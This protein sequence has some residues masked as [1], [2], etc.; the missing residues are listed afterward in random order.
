MEKGTNKQWIVLAMGMVCIFI[1]SGYANRALRKSIETKE[2]LNLLKASTDLM[3]ASVNALDQRVKTLEKLN[4]SSA[5]ND[6]AIPRPQHTSAQQLLTMGNQPELLY[7]GGAI[8]HIEI[9]TKN[10]D[11]SK[12]QK[13]KKKPTFSN[14]L[15]TFRDSL[16]DEQLTVLENRVDEVF[17]STFYHSIEDINLSNEQKEQLLNSI[18]VE[19]L[20][21][22]RK[23]HEE[24]ILMQ[25][26]A[27]AIK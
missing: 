3:A 5:S 20:E 15:K 16:N 23:S 19:Q 21:L 9:E 1:F 22:I 7:E 13:Q 2:Q 14:H 17:F 4:T 8:D 6:T 26:M 10:D 27:E 25:M 24:G 12:I 11:D 18:G